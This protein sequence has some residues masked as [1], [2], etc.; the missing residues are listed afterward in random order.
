MRNMDQ[1]NELNSPIMQE[2]CYFDGM[3]KRWVEDFDFMGISPLFQKIDEAVHNG[4]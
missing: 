4:N 1:S 3:H 2:P